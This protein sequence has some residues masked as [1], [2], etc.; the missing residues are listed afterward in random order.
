MSTNNAAIVNFGSSTSNYEFD[1]DIGSASIEQGYLNVN[2]ASGGK[3]QVSARNVTIGGGV[4]GGNVVINGNGGQAIFGRADSKLGAGDGS[5]TNL[6]HNG[7][8]VFNGTAAEN[9]VLDG[10]VDSLGGDIYFKG[11]GTFKAQGKIDKTNI[12]I[13]GS[14]SGTATAVF[15]FDTA[16]AAVEK[17]TANLSINNSKITLG[18]ASG[19]TSSTGVIEVKSGSLEIGKGSTLTAVTDKSA[20]KVGAGTS[21]AT[22]KISNAQLE[23]YLSRLTATLVLTTRLMQ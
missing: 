1:M 6:R 21:K 12:H 13:K 3:T 4:K 23:S 15:D 11:N 9:A 5:V 8:I 22:L 10:K 17:Q 7:E 14:G 18:N 20:I 19:S 2:A 16:L